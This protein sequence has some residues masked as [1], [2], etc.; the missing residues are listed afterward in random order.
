VDKKYDGDQMN[1]VLAIDEVSADLYTNFAHHKS[2][3]GLDG[4]YRPSGNA[5]LPKP[6]VTNLARYVE[7]TVVRTN[8]EERRMMELFA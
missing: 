8:E 7:D 1:L 2:T 6:T 5:W 4:P 3:Y